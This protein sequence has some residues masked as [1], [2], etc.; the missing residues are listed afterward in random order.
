MR[1]AAPPFIR[2]VTGLDVDALVAEWRWRIPPRQTP[3][4]VTILADW[5]FG[6]PDGRIWVLDSLEGDYRQIARTGAEYNANKSSE[7]W[8]K[9]TLHMEWYLAA[10]THGLVPQRRQC[11]GW[12]IHPRM[13][14]ALDVTNLQIASLQAY[15]S[16]M[17][18]LHRGLSELDGPR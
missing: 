10:L 8:L 12:K 6:A 16:L 1:P 18:Q 13:G 4:F 2:D 3:L 15:C 9:Q 14:G 7:K 17:G 11:I 5:I